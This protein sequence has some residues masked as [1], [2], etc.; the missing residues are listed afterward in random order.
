MEI[1]FQIYGGSSDKIFQIKKW[2]YLVTTNR[3]RYELMTLKFF[4]ANETGFDI[5]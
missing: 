5:F 3:G 2:M 4:A 1:T